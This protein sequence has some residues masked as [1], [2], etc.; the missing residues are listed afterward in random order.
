MTSGIRKKKIM[1]N[2]ME[3]EYL[4]MA[5]GLQEIFNEKNQKYRKMIEDYNHLYK[6]VCVIYGLVRTIQENGDEQ[7]LLEEVRAICS[8]VLFE[9]LQDED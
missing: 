9:H 2:I 1:N 5:N 3:G 7:F 8:D 4:E 6:K